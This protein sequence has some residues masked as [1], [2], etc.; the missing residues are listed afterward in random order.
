MPLLNNSD[1]VARWSITHFK[2]PCQPESYRWHDPQRWQK[3][4]STQI[5]NQK[6]GMISGQSYKQ[7]TLVNHDSR[8]IVTIKLLIFMTLDS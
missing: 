2:G 5:M 7:F 3:M 8:V 6:E 4:F 1:G